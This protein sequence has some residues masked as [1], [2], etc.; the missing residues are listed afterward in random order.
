MIKAIASHL[1]ITAI[2]MNNW[3]TSNDQWC[4]DLN[5][6]QLPI[7]P[8]TKN[9]VILPQLFVTPT[10]SAGPDGLAMLVRRDWAEYLQTGEKSISLSND[11]PP[12]LPL[13][14][15]CTLGNDQNVTKK[16]TVID[17]LMS[18]IWATC[19]SN[20]YRSGDSSE[21]IIEEK[22]FIKKDIK[23]IKTKGCT[24]RILFYPLL[25]TSLRTYIGESFSLLSPNIAQTASGDIV[26]LFSQTAPTFQTFMESANG[27]V[28]SILDHCEGM[29]N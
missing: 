12:Y 9:N 20:I 25:K 6:D 27:S 11:L 29:V 26:V 22:K 15:S 4:T 18:D 16:K 14:S 24:L 28:K 21:Q 7:F 3:S 1:K 5:N 23:D 8:S 19:L 13:L 17:K 2:Q 10:S